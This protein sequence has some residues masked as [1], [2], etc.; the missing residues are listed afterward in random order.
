MPTSANEFRIFLDEVGTS[1]REQQKTAR[2]QEETTQKLQNM[3]EA[4]SLQVKDLMENSR[5]LQNKMELQSHQVETLVANLEE[6]K[7]RNTRQ[8]EEHAE[9]SRKQQGLK[10]K[11]I[12]YRKR[13]HDKNKENCNLKKTLD[14][15]DSKA[16]A[17]RENF[18]T[19]LEMLKTENEQLNF[20]IENLRSAYSRISSDLMSKNDHT[21]ELA[22]ENQALNN[23]IKKLEQD[24]KEE[25]VVSYHGVKLPPLPERQR[26]K[27]G[28]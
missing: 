13:L 10:E 19:Q 15:T 22:R 11:I 21:R 24:L 18:L 2:L 12:E 6:E 7:E 23:I 14:E 4:Q 20:Q 26:F 28:K 16:Q 27:F 17:E 9:L 3:V 25:K 1:V 5:L 8:K